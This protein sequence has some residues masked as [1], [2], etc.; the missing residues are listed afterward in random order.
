VQEDQNGRL[1]ELERRVAEL[2]RGA[3]KDQR[4]ARLRRWAYLLAALVYVLYLYW[5]SSSLP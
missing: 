1:L 5:V 2:E 4:S 3:A